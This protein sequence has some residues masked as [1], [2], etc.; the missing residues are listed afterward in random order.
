MV[1]DHT[2]DDVVSL[3]DIGIRHAFNRQVVSLTAAA[4]KHNLFFFRPDRFRY[5]RS[6]QIDR[7]P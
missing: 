7:L 2:C 5:F 4:G 6:C 1:F 3:A